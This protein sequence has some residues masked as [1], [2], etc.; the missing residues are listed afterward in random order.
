VIR[1]AVPIVLALAGCDG[2]FGLQHISLADATAGP[3]APTDAP[4][5]WETPQ[6][7]TLRVPGGHFASDITLD[8]EE[9]VV[10]YAAAMGSLWDVFEAE[11]TS[12]TLGGSATLVA[13]DVEI[14]AGPELSPDG[15][16]LY[17]MTYETGITGAINM[18]TRSAV[19]E[20]WGPTEQ[21]T[22]LNRMNEDD[23]PGSPDASGNYMVIA[24]SFDLH[25]M[26]KMGGAWTRI[27]TCTAITD[28]LQDS[29]NPHLSPDGLRLVYSGAPIY[30]VGAL[31]L[32]IS[33]RSAL[34]APWSAPVRL[35]P[36]STDNVDETDPW[37][38]ADGKRLWFNRAQS[39]LF[40]QY[41]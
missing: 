38:S 13:G 34:G 12:P 17:Y 39:V 33:T 35:V 20:S 40:T 21:P 26:Q 11:M 7:V 32:W 9:K 3:D 27:D 5:V 30:A 24:R 37:M 41:K 31:D 36:M 6:L 1:V 28:V 10:A 18:R 23:R 25:E 14:E 16:T 15:L 4:S 22:D 8:Q 29:R 2:V 19:T